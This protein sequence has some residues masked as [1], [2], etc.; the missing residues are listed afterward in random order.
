[1]STLPRLNLRKITVLFELHDGHR[2]EG[3]LTVQGKGTRFSDHVSHRDREFFALEG[4]TIT[5]PHDSSGPLRVPFLMLARR[6]VRMMTPLD[7]GSASA[8]PENRH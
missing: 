4:V 8:E 1:M 7:E 2:V 3:T 5:T 6:Y